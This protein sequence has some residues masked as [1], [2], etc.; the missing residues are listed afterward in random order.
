M[1]SVFDALAILKKEGIN[2]P[3]FIIMGSGPRKKEFECYA[4]EKKVLVW[5]TGM[6]PYAQMCGLLNACDITI[7][8]IASNSAGS[9]INKHADYAAAGKPVINTQ[10]SK[11]YRELVENYQMGFNCRNGNP[12]DIAD[13]LIVLLNDKKLRMQ[14][15]QNARRCANERFD[16]KDS[17]LRLTNMIERLCE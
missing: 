8:P 15:G 9:I 14:M 4:K 16:R 12:R 1:I 2:P 11:E 17:Y 7:N 3:Q 13:K 5:F 10:E 6:L